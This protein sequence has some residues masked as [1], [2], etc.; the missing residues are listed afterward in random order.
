MTFQDKKP[1]FKKN[2]LIYNITYRSGFGNNTRTFRFQLG[3][4]LPGLNACIY[5]I[6]EEHI[7]GAN[8]AFFVSRFIIYI[9]SFQTNEIVKYKQISKYEEITFNIQYMI[10]DED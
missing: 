6:E 3:Q 9:Y 2:S 4:N 7:R 10:D 5:N 1:V 8:D